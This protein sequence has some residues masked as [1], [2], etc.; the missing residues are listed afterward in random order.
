M[1]GA[2]TCRKHQPHSTGFSVQ[3]TTYQDGLEGSC[4]NLGNHDFDGKHDRI[5]DREN[6]AGPERERQLQGL[7]DKPLR[8]GEDLDDLTCDRICLLGFGLEPG[9]FA[10]QLR[11]VA[12]IP[13]DGEID[14]L[15]LPLL[16]KDDGPQ[17][18]DDGKDGR[19][20]GQE[21]IRSST[22]AGRNNEER[23]VRLEEC[24]IKSHL[25]SLACGGGGGG[26]VPRMYST[27]L[28]AKHIPDVA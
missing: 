28:L 18:V 17:T 10:L 13:P 5:E 8:S 6:A 22:K 27:Y 1:A 14:F 4:I 21:E 26:A 9:P 24:K 11:D 15:A 19:V 7:P 23:E 12:H 20:L 25:H 16:H 2:K 3:Q